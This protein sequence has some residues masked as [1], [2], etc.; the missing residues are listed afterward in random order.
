MTAIIASTNIESGVQG[1]IIDVVDNRANIKDP[2][3]PSS[4]EKNRTFVYDSD[5]FQK[6]ITFEDM[7]Y[8]IVELPKLDYENVSTDGKHKNLFWRQTLTV[9]SA[10]DGCSNSRTGVG[11]TD[12]LAIGNDI[13]S[14]F[15]SETIKAN[16]RGYNMY[17]LKIVKISAETIS[18]QQKEAY[19][20][21]YEL[22][23]ET[24]MK[25]SS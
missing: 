17:E 16:L 13:N 2:R 11:Y 18:I 22:S 1:N 15:N 9:R 6:C 10:R 23:Y 19:E 3:S 24:R 20:S 14:T 8:I 4:N 5:P 12:I 21:Q 25:V 7:P